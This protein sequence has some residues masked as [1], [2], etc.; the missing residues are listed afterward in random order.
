[1]RNTQIT[2][3]IYTLF[4]GVPVNFANIDQQLHITSGRL[5]RIHILEGKMAEHLSSQ[6]TTLGYASNLS[7]SIML[8][9]R[10]VF[11]YWILMSLFWLLQG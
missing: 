6:H 10:G 11:C 1:M 4:S 7:I 9:A 8:F 2:L 5:K 3:D